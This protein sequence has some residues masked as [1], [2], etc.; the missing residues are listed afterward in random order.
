MQVNGC[1]GD[2]DDNYMYNNECTFFPVNICGNTCGPRLRVMVV[3][4]VV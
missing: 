1:V 2:K 3:V 4:V